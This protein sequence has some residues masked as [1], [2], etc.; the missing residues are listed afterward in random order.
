MC[1]F[2]DM[3]DYVMMREGWRENYLFIED[4]K[5]MCNYDK[6]IEK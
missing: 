1:A 2:F 3:V 5:K 6:M 4:M